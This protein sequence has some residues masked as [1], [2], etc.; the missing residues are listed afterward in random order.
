MTRRLHKNTSSTGRILTVTH[1]HLLFGWNLS[2][3]HIILFFIPLRHDTFVSVLHWHVDSIVSVKASVFLHSFCWFSIFTG[4]S[5]S[6]TLL[7]I[8]KLW[9]LLGLILLCSITRCIMSPQRLLV[10]SFL[11][12]SGIIILSS[13]VCISITY[14]SLSLILIQ[15]P[16]I[17][18]LSTSIE[19]FIFLIDVR[20][21][22]HDQW[23][24][25]ILII[26]VVIS[27][28]SKRLLINYFLLLFAIT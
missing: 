10:I 6:N 12:V 4:F 24:F 13:S 14:N 22:H 16:S 19:F 3:A 20:L 5:W 25:L 7:Q 8:I 1:F 26:G 15:G 2:E 21:L 23:A 11:H 9:F 28:S 18:T 27:L 17:S